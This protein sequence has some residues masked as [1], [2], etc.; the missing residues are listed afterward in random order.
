[1]VAGATEGTSISLGFRHKK[2]LKALINIGFWRELWYNM[3]TVKFV[4]VA[5]FLESE[6]VHYECTIEI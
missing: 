1:M 3:S 2:T 5:L 6:V 4:T